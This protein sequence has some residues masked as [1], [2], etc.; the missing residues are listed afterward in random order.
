[1]PAGSSTD[2]CLRQFV[3]DSGTGTDALV[4]SL[5]DTMAFGDVE[6]FLRRHGGKNALNQ[7]RLDARDAAIRELAA[8]RTE[9][10]GRA[11]A[12]AIRTDLIRYGASGYRRSAPPADDR[13]ALLHKILDLVGDRKIPSA[14]QL[15]E[16]LAG[17]RS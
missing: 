17:K 12:K 8:G 16:I 6:R 5:L 7:R 3:L 4:V 1:M 9:G 15:R 13:R 14:G 10:S 2:P 11:L